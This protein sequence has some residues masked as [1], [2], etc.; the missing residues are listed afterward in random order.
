MKGETL[1]PR[2]RNKNCLDPTNNDLC[3]AWKNEKPQKTM[4]VM[5]QSEWE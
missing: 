3:K 4:R 1:N 2:K 5:N